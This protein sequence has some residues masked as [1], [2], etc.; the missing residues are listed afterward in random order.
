MGLV[1][2]ITSCDY[3][4]D[5]GTAAWQE[6]SMLPREYITKSSRF[7]ADITHKTCPAKLQEVKERIYTL[8]ILNVHEG[9]GTDMNQ[10]Q[11]FSQ[12]CAHNKTKTF[13]FN[14]LNKIPDLK[15]MKVSVTNQRF[16]R[17]KGIVHPNQKK[18]QYFDLRQ[19]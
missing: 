18:D 12:D 3:I 6:V 15:A 16:H 19:S 14:V 8:P 7:G 10:V 4:D 5:E 1:R 2:V 17:V 11:L 9:G 13:K